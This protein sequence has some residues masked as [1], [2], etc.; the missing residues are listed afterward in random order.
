MSNV[1]VVM[2]GILYRN[3]NENNVGSDMLTKFRNTIIDLRNSNVNNIVFSHGPA[4]FS[5][6]EGEKKFLEEHDVKL[7]EVDKSLV[8]TTGKVNLFGQKIA[9]DEGLKHTT[10]D[11]ILRHRTEVY[12]HKELLDWVIN[13]K[14]LQ[15]PIKDGILKSK[16]WIPWSNIN[17][18]WYCADETFFGHRDDIKRMVQIDR[19][20]DEFHPKQ[21]GGGS[22]TRFF[23]FPFMN[24]EIWQKYKRNFGYGAGF[25]QPPKVKDFTDEY[26]EYLGNY[27]AILYK[28]YRVYNPKNQIDFRLTTKPTRSY[29]PDFIKNFDI[30]GDFRGTVDWLQ[31][32]NDNIIRKLYE[33]EY[34]DSISTKIR[35]V[36]IEVLKKI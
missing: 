13:N 30:V 35:N 24:I 17:R 25:P 18:P 5:L 7:I 8:P 4:P 12:I 33:G 20:W 21:G 22:P 36:M 29:S 1:D 19:S 11:Y 14:E 23:I 27:Y 34:K 31:M 26:I 15:T 6:R 16:I 32:F 28:Y 3:E 2:T 10:S 9:I